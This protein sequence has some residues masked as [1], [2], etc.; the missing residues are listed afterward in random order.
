MVRYRNCRRSRNCTNSAS[1]TIRGV[2][3]PTEFH[4]SG[5]IDLLYYGHG[6]RNVMFHPVQL[7]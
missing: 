6:H 5:T 2:Q 1:V 4:K 3:A 7:S